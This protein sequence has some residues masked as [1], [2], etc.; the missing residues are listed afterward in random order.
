MSNRTNYN[1]AYNKATQKPNEEQIAVVKSSDAETVVE[2]QVVEEPAVEAPMVETTVGVV[3]NCD[4]LNVRSQ[5]SL[6]AP[7]V[8]VLDKGTEIEVD[9]GKSANDF[10]AVK[11]GYCM[12]KYITLKQ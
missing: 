3:S 11:G 4:R 1:K 2:S 6:S 8:T 10:Y 7:V 12:I 5:P 9:L